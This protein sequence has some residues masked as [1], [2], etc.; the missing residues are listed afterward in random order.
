MV[1][2]SNC[3][4]SWYDGQAAECLHHSGDIEHG[5]WGHTDLARRLSPYVYTVNAGG[6][7]IYSKSLNVMEYIIIYMGMELEY[8]M[9]TYFFK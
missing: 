9:F 1:H 5:Q 2:I 8:Y 6:I 4:S 7:P 3:S